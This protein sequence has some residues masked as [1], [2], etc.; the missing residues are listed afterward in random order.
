[1]KKISITLS[2]KVRFGA[3]P[4]GVSLEDFGNELDFSFRPDADIA[5]L[6]DA[7]MDAFEATSEGGIATHRV[8][9]L[10]DEGAVLGQVINEMDYKIESGIDGCPVTGTEILGFSVEDAE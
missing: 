5:L 2:T 10:V 8:T 6:A 3:L 9:L 4:A 1:M 7:R